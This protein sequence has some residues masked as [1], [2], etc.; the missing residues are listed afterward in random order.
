MPT[1]SLPVVNVLQRLC[2]DKGITFVQDL[3]QSDYPPAH[4]NTIQEVK[5]LG[6][7]QFDTF[8]TDENEAA[9]WRLDLKVRVL[10][11]VEVAKRCRR[12]NESTW[13]FACEPY[14]LARLRSEV[15]CTNCRK[16]LWRSEIEVIRDGSHGEVPDSLQRRQANRAP[17]RCSRS[18]RPDD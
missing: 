13:R 7:T 16:R 11:L 9:P 14:V 8:A 4:A 15:V 18:N 17:C 1:L 6:E 5:R 3:A 10:N 2:R 12:R